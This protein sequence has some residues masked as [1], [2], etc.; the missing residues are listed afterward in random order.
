MGLILQ[1]GNSSQI[2]KTPKNF[3]RCGNWKFDGYDA[4]MDDEPYVTC[5]ASKIASVNLLLAVYMFLTVFVA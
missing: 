5:G 2:P 1:V 3:P 4:E